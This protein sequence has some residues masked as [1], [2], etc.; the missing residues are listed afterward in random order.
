MMKY[1]SNSRFAKSGI[2]FSVFLAPLII[3]NIEAYIDPGTGSLILQI[4][5]ASL[6]GSLFLL[7]VFWRKVKTF[8]TNVFSRD[9]NRND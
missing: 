9:N 3:F 7:K 8:F 1:K 5:I 2:L 4:V 6:V